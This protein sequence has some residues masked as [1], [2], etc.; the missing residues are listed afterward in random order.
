MSLDFDPQD[1]LKTAGDARRHLADRLVTPLWFHPVIGLAVAAICLALGMPEGTLDRKGRLYL[2][3]GTIIVNALLVP[4]L[5]RRKTG[6]WVQNAVGPR[7]RR[8]IVLGAIPLA[9]LFIG[10]GANYLVHGP[11]LV[12]V[13]MGVISVVGVTAFGRNYD[14]VVRDELREGDPQ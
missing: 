5:Y 1:A 8:L 12:P 13:I 3:M 6:M 14:S 4:Q 9:A 2:L 10:A 7:S 11:W